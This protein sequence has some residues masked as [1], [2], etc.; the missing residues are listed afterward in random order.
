MLS[1]PLSDVLT[2]LAAMTRAITWIVVKLAARPGAAMP[3][4]DAIDFTLAAPNPADGALLDPS[5]GQQ[6]IP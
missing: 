5:R 4:D 3:R 1:A 6:I 2:I